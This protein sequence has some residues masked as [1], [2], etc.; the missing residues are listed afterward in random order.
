MQLLALSLPTAAENLALDE[1]LL[2]QAE[3]S[4]GT[5]Q[6]LLRLW[7][8]PEPAVVLGR[9][10]KVAEEVDQAACANAG[11]AILR[12]ASGGGTVAIGPGC[13]QYSVVLKTAEFPA[14]ASIAGAH[15]F[16]LERVA[17][18]VAAALVARRGGL[19]PAVASAA[20]QRAGDSDLLWNSRKFSG[21]SL[22]IK[23]HCVLYHGTLLYDYPLARVSALLREPARQ[24]EYRGRKPHGEFIA[25][26]PVSA[27]DLRSA[28]IQVWNAFSPAA[29]WPREQ[30]ARL[31]AEKYRS[32]AWNL[33]R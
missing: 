13:L 18:A 7:E 26:L 14:A 16:V 12:R 3:A 19:T 32:D 6:S 27:A 15:A 17:Q 25:N 29:D 28:L 11:V 33:E 20:V 24:P 21:N 1:A 10:G 30:V 5:A 4:L 8:S 23:R 2:E 31:T 9:S 22:R